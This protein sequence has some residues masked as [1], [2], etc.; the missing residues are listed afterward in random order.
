MI[1]RCPGRS[2]LPSGTW[3]NPGRYKRFARGLELQPE[4]VCLLLD[5][6]TIKTG[7]YRESEKKIASP[8]ALRRLRSIDGGLADAFVRV[9]HGN[10]RSRDEK[11]VNLV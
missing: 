9:G 11:Q 8:H 6:I 3:R 4:P 10:N 1:V 2:R 5:R 7:K